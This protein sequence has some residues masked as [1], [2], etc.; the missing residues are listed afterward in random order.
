M[1]STTWKIED[2]DPIFAK[3]FRAAEA[4]VAQEYLE[5]HPAW[6]RFLKTS[7]FCQLRGQKK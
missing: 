4:K 2:T 6:Q 5:A 7:F 1:A 3:V